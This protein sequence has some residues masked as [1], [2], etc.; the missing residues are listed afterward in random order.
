MRTFKVKVKVP[1][2]SAIK[3]VDCIFN[4]VTCRTVH[5]IVE[6]QPLP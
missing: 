2:V 1:T 6:S 4:F 5:R 3:G